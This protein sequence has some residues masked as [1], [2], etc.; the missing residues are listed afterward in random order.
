MESTQKQTP[1]RKRHT[2]LTIRATEDEKALIM[3][4]TE[5]SGL[6]TFNLYALTM[7]IRGEIKKIDLTHYHELAKEVNRIGT[8]INQIAKSVNTTGRIYESE[9]AELQE[10]MS[11]I[12]QLLKSN[13]SALR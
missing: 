13:L 6:G 4:K 5:W 11:D 2:T 1:R 3:K 9:I 10:R 8:N 7:L 12:W